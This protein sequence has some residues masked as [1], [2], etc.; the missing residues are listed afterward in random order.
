L[1]RLPK[2]K[3]RQAKKWLALAHCGHSILL[4][5]THKMNFIDKL[6][7]QNIYATVHEVKKRKHSAI[8]D[9]DNVTIVDRLI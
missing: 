2:N 3:K 1:E 6:L 5:K 8:T 7:R 4:C 9:C